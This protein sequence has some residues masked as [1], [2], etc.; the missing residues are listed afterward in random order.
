MTE[1]GDAL[2]AALDT[3]AGE[4]PMSLVGRARTSYDT[5]RRLDLVGLGGRPWRTRLTRRAR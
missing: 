1:I 3:S 5:V 4:E 2:V